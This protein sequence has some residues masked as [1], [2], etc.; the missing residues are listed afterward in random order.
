MTHIVV[1]TAGHIDHGKSTLVRALTGIDPDR[2]KEEKARGITIELGF[3]HARIGDTT[4]AFVDVPGHERFV[5]TMLAGAGGVDCVMLVVA[6]DESVM[7]Q[8][9]EHFD[10]CRLLHVPHGLVVITKSDLADADTLELVRLEVRDLVKGSFLE[11]APVVAVSSE[12]GAGLDDLRAALLELAAAVHQR[13]PDGWARLPIDRAFSMQGFGTVVTG[14]MIAGRIAIEDELALVPGD[15][16]VRVRGLQVHGKKREHASS[17]ERTAINLGGIDVASISRGQQLVAPGALTITR[18]L[19]AVLDLLPTARALK[20]GARV[21]FHQGTSELMGRVSIAASA[22]GDVLPGTSAVV[23]IRLEGG[24]A[25]TRGD[26]F[27]IRAYSPT[28]T[29][30]GGTIIDPDP[31]RSAVRTAA[32]ERRF[33]ALTGPRDDAVLQMVIDTGAMGLSIAALSS[34]AGESPAAA[35]ELANALHNGGAA[36]RVGDRLVSTEVLRTLGSQLTSVVREF[37]RTQPLADGIP[38]EEARERVFARAHASVFD[39]VLSELAAQKQ[40]VGRERLALAGHRL[41]LDP[42]EARARDVIAQAFKRAGLK[43]PDTA[44]I[45]AEARVPAALVE[46]MTAL[47]V[48]QKQLQR[49]DTLLFHVDALQELK[50]EIQ[51][52]KA[53]APEGRAT[54]DVAM[55]KDR[56]GVTRKFAIPLL[57]WL[58]RERVTRRVGETRVVL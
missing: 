24:A 9:R 10:I 51:A 32:A 30:G 5:R 26:R 43:P 37:H 23:R 11:D 57:E 8:T 53:S 18:R 19:D 14:T 55:F 31:P 6:A 20:H 45:V 16:R 42:E 27:I 7:P 41:A 33:R 2:L 1:G 38:R 46:K 49:V 47:L 44:T 22:R 54:V 48:R 29:I 50:G 12:T 35:N 13:R 52:L 3:A 40:V 15:T 34:R 28:V 56:F 39:Y 17:G 58:D 21:R 25:V 36:R 4:L